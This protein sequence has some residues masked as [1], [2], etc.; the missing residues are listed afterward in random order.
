M[1]RP[2]PIKIPNIGVVDTLTEF[3]HVD[4]ADQPTANLICASDRQYTVGGKT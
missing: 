2:R 3:S 1:V 4:N